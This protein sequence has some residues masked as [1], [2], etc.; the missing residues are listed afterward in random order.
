MRKSKKFLIAAIVSGAAALA[1]AIWV[2]TPFLH[3]LPPALSSVGVIGGADGPTA[4]VVS[5]GKTGV[6]AA[7]MVLLLPVL[8]AAA[9][10][11]CLVFWK[12]FRKKGE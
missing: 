4:V 5:G 8:L 12:K 10:V 3:L 2:W 11:C 1:A 6:W 9:A 7:V